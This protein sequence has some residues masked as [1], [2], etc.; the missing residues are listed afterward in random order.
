M[1]EK[2]AFLRRLASATGA[3]LA[4]SAGPVHATLIWEAHVSQGTSVFKGIGGDGNCGTGSITGF[5]DSQRGT[6]WRYH[7]PSS[8]GRC[9][10]HGIAVNGSGYYF[11]NGRTYYLGWFSRLSTSANNNANFQWKS[12][13]AHIQNYPIVIKMISGRVHLLQRQPG[14]SLTTIWSTPLSAN[15]WNHFVLGISLSQETRGGAIEFWYNG[16][17]QTFV[18]GTQRYMCRTYDSG[19]HNCPKWG[20]YGGTGTDMSNYVDDLRVGT[21]YADVAMDGAPIT[22]TPTP[23]P[24]STP[25]PTPTPTA[26]STPP[27]EFLEIT[28]PASSVT[29]ST[30]DSNVPGNT[31]DNNLLTRWSGNGDGTWIQYDLGGL[32]RV[33]H[34]NVAVYQ[35]NMRRNRF[36][37]QVATTLGAWTTLFT[38]ESSGATTAEQTYELPDTDARWVRYLGHGNVG[39]SNPSMNSVTE[40]SIFGP[41]MPTITPSPTPTPTSE[42][43]V[44]P[45]PPTTP[46]ELTPPGSSVSASTNDGNLPANTVDDSLSTRWSGNGD[47]AWIQ[48]DLGATRTITSVAIAWYQGNTRVSTFDV[49]ASDSSTGPWTTLAAGRTSGGTTTALETYDVMDGSGRYLRLVAHGNTLN[50]WNSMTEVQVWGIP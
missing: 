31:V 44:T 10:N 45:T 19:N 49:L 3:F 22:P 48:Y 37:I 15:V 7:K 36:E 21:A 2:M 9:E 30:S 34:V 50:G 39:S 17:R 23:T 11:Q 43:T 12:Y 35:G 29:A 46:V 42:P 6:V 27:G 26:T 1:S 32:R 13:E 20:I 8:S 25:G 24:T 40:V 16:I 33:T 28:P 38:G 47:G 41:G 18:N 5:S 14:E 4:I